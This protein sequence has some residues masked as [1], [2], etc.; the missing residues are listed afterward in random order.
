MKKNAS[1]NEELVN[2]GILLSR[3]FITFVISHEIFLNI[4]FYQELHSFERMI[5]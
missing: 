4:S 1:T 5:N 3:I 2:D